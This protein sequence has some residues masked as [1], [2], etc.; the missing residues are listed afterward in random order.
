MSTLSLA[1]ARDQPTLSDRYAILLALALL[2]YAIAGKGFA[3]LGVPPLFVG[4]FTLLLGIL[5]FLRTG[6]WIAV[7]TT[8]SSL[9]MA[10]LIAWV[11]A[12]S[13]PLIGIYGVDS[14]RDAVIVLYG[15]FAFITIA[16]LL[17]KPSR[18]DQAFGYFAWFTA[19]FGAIGPLL[20]FTTRL[21]QNVIPL[22]PGTETP[23]LNIRAGE[24]ACHLSGAAVFALL[25][26]RRVGIAWTLMLLGGI[27][28]IGA[29]SRGGMLAILVPVAFALV[30]SGRSRVLILG[31]IGLGLILGTLYALDVEFSI[32]GD[33]RPLG[34]RQVVDNFLSVFGS[35]ENAQLDGTKK[36]RV[37]WWTYIRNYT[38]HGDYF[39]TGKG[40]GMNLAVVDGFVVGDENLPRVRSPHSAHMTMLGRSGV[41]GLVLWGLTLAS[42]LITL[43]WNMIVARL[44]SHREWA[45]RFLFLACY[46]TAIII[47]ASFDVALEGPMIGIWFW[48][49][50]GLSIGAVMIYRA[51]PR[52]P[53]RRMTKSTG[54]C[55]VGR[56]HEPN[57]RHHLFP[58]GPRVA[59]VLSTDGKDKRCELQ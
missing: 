2:G 33:E 6:A 31:A 3:Y 54:A 48:V 56:Q 16:L 49:L 14:I 25:G 34:A 29:Q 55:E 30:V 50:F 15:I 35:S 59:D 40:F 5:V 8:P 11:L 47:D 18:I 4:E 17:E 45:N 20:Y 41:P 21:F 57:G 27:V 24:V 22:V 43:I 58:K 52:G 12:R 53:M 7:L 32:P 26:M 39:W 23:L 42:I 9:L 36:W 46:L 38:F 19:L 37:E 44:R 1:T 28:I 51:S 13:I 10:V